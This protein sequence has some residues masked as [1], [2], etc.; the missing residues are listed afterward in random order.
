MQGAGRVRR[1]D[2]I[3]LI[4]GAAAMPMVARAQQREHIKRIGALMVLSASDQ[5]A[6]ARLAAFLTGLN[7]AGWIEGRNIQ[8]DVR[9]TAGRADEAV[10]YARELVSLAPDAL[11]AGGGSTVGPLRQ[12]TGTIPIVFVN[13][14]DPVG[15]GHV[16]SLAHPGGNATGFTQFEFSI[17][18]KWLELLKQTAPELK[19]VGVIRDPQISAGV[20]QW[21]AIQ[22]VAP[23]LGVDVTPL[24]VRNAAEIER[25]IG[26]FARAGKAGLIVTSGA[27]PTR[28]RDPIVKQAARHRL[29]GI[30]PYRFFTMS[31]GLMSYGPDNVHPF[32]DAA[33]Y[34]SRILKGEK[35]ADLP[36]QA[37]TKYELVINLKA[38]KA[39]GLTIPPTLLARADKV[40]E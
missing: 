40:I 23:G 9:W 7:E 10:K 28:H 24:D 16:A 14:S 12:A 3:A 32:A 30:Y 26:D 11:L 31:G 34:I 22:A 37:P 29:P 2:F 5:L 1:R 25:A 38:A 39:I 19:R 20:G 18:A 17:G 36:V 13:T 35:P 27:L 8:I 15:A 4:G 21:G 6:Q 33:S